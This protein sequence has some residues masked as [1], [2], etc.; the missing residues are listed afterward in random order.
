MVAVTAFARPWSTQSGVEDALAVGDA[1]R[2]RESLVVPLDASDTGSPT[3]GMPLV[4]RTVTRMTA[5]EL[6]SATTLPGIDWIV[7]LLAFA[8][9]PPARS[10]L[11]AIARSAALRSARFESAKS[12]AP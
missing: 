8:T 11:A 10:V 5:L 12:G 6:P 2:G 1:A 9:D 7:D 4:S 3:T